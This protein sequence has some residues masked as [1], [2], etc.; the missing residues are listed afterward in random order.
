MSKILLIGIL[1][2]VLLLAGCAGT[3][4]SVTS[5]PS[6]EEGLAPP[7]GDEEAPVMPTPAEFKVS[8]L[9]VTPSEVIPGET[10]TITAV[11][12]NTGGSEGTYTA[13]LTTDGFTVEEKEVVI[14]SGSS[15]IITFSLVEDAPGTHEIGVGELSS[16]LVVEKTAVIKVTADPN[17][18]TCYNGQAGW[19]L[20][21]TET[22]GIGV[23][24]QNL[25]TYTYEGKIPV[26]SQSWEMSDYLLPYGTLT[27]TSGCDHCGDVTFVLVVITG[28]DDNGHVV[29]G[30]LQVAILLPSPPRSCFNF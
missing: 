19:T 6:E 3:T 22:N 14:A 1:I 28:V 12:E 26:S 2:A 10:V 7:D 25:T 23:T 15:E 5:L 8:S 20:I 18:A 30:E 29:E 24:L 16:T 9:D 4:E 13:I 17:P 27:V 21:F 11:V